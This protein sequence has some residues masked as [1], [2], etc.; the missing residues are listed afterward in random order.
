MRAK[1]FGARV[2]P[3][4]PDEARTFGMEGLIKEFAIYT[5]FGQRYV[6]VDAE[7][8]LS[9]AESARGQIL[10][11]GITE[12]GSVASL[13]AAATSYA[14]H[15]QP[16]IPFYLFYSMFGFQRTMDQ[17]WAAADARGRGFMMGATAGRTTLSG[18]GLQ[19]CDG[20]SH[21]LASAVPSIRPY[22]PA[23]AYE[24]AVI[25]RDGLRRMFER[26]ED[27]IYY[28][29]I[30][31]ENYE[32]P[33]MPDGAENGILQGLY[34][35][36]EAP[37]THPHRAQILASGPIL[38][39][40]LEA[41]EILHERYDVG[42]DVW[43]ATSFTLLRREALAC[44]EWNREH[45]ES[46]PKTSLVKKLLEPTQGPILGVSDWVRS[47][48]DQIA[49]WAPRKFI[50]L[51]TDGFG[52]S[53]TRTA[54]R[55]SFGIDGPSI[56]QTVLTAL[57]REGRIPAEIAAQARRDLELD[58]DSREKT[59]VPEPETV[60]AGNGQGRTRTGKA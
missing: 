10:E 55:R 17:I 46:Q 18:E 4:V 36:R 22:D 15:G 42:A 45:P 28:M 8:L 57:A 7:L 26:G 35:Y 54:L 41:Q 50:S 51:G 48:P 24:V 29:T 49:R 37:G 27:V 21:L 19:H 32:M 38:R 6:P 60:P 5:P 23:F 59:P 14:T 52:M 12:A 33:A 34:R 58:A 47:F 16:T 56:A 2:V 1:D 40:A 39:C 25:V 31:N 44:E 30:Y 20:H 3:I 43:S 9:Y 13:T 53:D 11:E